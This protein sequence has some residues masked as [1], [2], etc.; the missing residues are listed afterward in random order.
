MWAALL[1][2][3]ARFWEVFC[4]RRRTVQDPYRVVVLGAGFAG[5]VRA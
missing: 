4:P 2:V 5:M 1:G 3:L